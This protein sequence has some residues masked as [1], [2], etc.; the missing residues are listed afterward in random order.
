MINTHAQE[1]LTEMKPSLRKELVDKM[2]IFTENIF[3]R[4]PY[5]IMVTDD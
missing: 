5:D 1:L 3:A 2:K 4:I